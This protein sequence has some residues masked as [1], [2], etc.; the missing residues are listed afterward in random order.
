MRVNRERLRK[1][2]YSKRLAKKIK[3]DPNEYKAS[4]E[5]LKKTKKLM[6]DLC[7]KGMDD[8]IIHSAVVV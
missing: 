6:A 3:E 4:I 1:T 2:K 8:E 5:D 7:K